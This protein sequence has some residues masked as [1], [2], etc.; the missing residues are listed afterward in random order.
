VLS[1]NVVF[2][3]TKATTTEEE[4]GEATTMEEAEAAAESVRQD[5]QEANEGTTMEQIK[6]CGSVFFAFLD[7]SR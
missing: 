1:L 7:R 6:V 4:E 3:G 2:K 5:R